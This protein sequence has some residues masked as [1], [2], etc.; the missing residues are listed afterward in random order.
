[1]EKNW[2]KGIARDVM[3]LGSIPFYFIVIIRAIIGKYAIFVY[4]LLIAAIILFLLMKIF[5]KSNA[6]IARGLIL[7]VFTSLFYRDNLYTTFAFLLWIFMLISGFY[8]KIKK[9]EIIK[10]VLFGVIAA[11]TSY[12]LS[13][14]IARF[15]NFQFAA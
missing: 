12:Y 9:N 11:S 10:G 5:R 6:H 1:M 15:I 13:P 8:I 2:K 7:V 4:Q 3:A 14:F